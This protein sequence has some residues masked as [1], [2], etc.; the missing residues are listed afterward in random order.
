MIAVIVLLATS[1]NPNPVEITVL[2]VFL[3]LE[4]YLKLRLIVIMAIIALS[5]ILCIMFVCYICCC[6]P[7]EGSFKLDLKPKPA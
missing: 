7:R 5:P 6:R 4:S 2:I 3:V 1:G